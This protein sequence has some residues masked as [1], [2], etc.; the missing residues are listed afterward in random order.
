V[1]R[2]P[3]PGSP[4]D[5]PRNLN[6]LAYQ[7][8]KS[9]II[10]GRLEGDVIYSAGQFAEMLSVSRSPVR[11]AL[12]QLAA[13]GYLALVDGR[14][15]KIRQFS[16]KEIRDIF[17]MRGLI[18]A[19]AVKRF[20]DLMSHEDQEQ[21]KHNLRLMNR[22]ADE[23]NAVQLLEADK[24]FHMIPVRRCNNHLLSSIMENIRNYI[25]IFGMKAISDKGRIHAVIDEHDRIL[26]ALQKKDK[27]N[28]VR[29]VRHH[30]LTTQQYLLSGVGQ[31]NGA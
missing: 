4:I 3:L 29:A 23:G 26:E 27:M 18:E 5:R 13:E 28:V 7:E 2:E 31:S 22:W 1:L 24:E 10:S 30:L 11:E 15:F 21:L 12:L 19:H 20:V 17:E 6:E 25:S 14:G 8:I 9:Q 16:E